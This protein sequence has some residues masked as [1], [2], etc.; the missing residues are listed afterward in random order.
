MKK[1]IAMTEL[2]LIILVVAG[3]IGLILFGKQA[4]NKAECLEAVEVCKESN[5]LFKRIQEKIALELRV[6]CPAISPPN[7]NEQV[8]KGKDKKETMHII[9]ENL[10]WC[11]EKTLGRQNTMG[12]DF[13]QFLSVLG[14]GL[15]VSDKVDFCLVCSEFVPQVD[16]TAQEWDNYLDTNKVGK[17]TYAE[18]INPVV[19][20]V[21]F[22]RQD[23]PG[24]WGYHDIGFKKGVRYYVVSVD[25][26]ESDSRTNQPEYPVRIYID[27]EIYCGKIDP[28]IHYERV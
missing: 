12:K 19:P 13:A 23:K 9:A 16:I 21:C 28:Q 11:W 7:C 25:A 20:N 10:R 5:V 3:G 6:N 2:V 18:L 27:P 8:L 22:D 26:W 24:C 14:V 17:Q 1:A 4:S 15:G